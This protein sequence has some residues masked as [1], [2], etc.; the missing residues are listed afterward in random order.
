MDSV[1]FLCVIIIAIV[2]GC[3]EL[4]IST[5][6]KSGNNNSLFA[7]A[8]DNQYVRTGSRVRLD[9]SQSYDLNLLLTHGAWIS[10]P[11]DQLLQ[12]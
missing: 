10:H 3:D 6:N 5:N 11:K 1:K 7:H 2:S 12:S 8:G 4:S 9:A